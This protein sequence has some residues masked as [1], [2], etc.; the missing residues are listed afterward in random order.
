M[1]SSESESTAPSASPAGTWSAVPATPCLRSDGESS[2]EDESLRSS[3]EHNVVSKQWAGAAKGQ[4][5]DQ[6]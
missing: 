3:C 6:E 4:R 1:P 5:G 2:L